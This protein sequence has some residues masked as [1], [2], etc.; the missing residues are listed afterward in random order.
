MTRV[1]RIALTETC[2]VYP[3]MPESLSGVAALE[4]KLEDIRQANI[5]HHLQLA[6]K[7]ADAGVELLVCGE[8]FSAPYFA[9]TA[10]PMWKAMAE[11]ASDGPTVAAMSLAA[12]NHGM[13]IVAPIYEQ[14]ESGARFN[15][16]M[17]IDETG[18]VIG[19]Y[20]KSHIPVGQN[21]QGSFAE[22]FYYGPSD[23][24]NG[25]WEANIS[26]N[27]YFPVFQTSIGK[28]GVAICYDRH[29]DGVMRTLAASGAELVVSPAVTFGEKSERMW[30]MEFEV[31]AA[32][33][34][35][36]IAGSN[37]KGAEKPW[38]QDYFGSSYVTGPNGRRPRIDIGEPA[39]VVAE[40]DLG[41]LHRPDPSGW[42]LARDYRK[43]IYS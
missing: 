29:F 19:K 38:D 9:S 16:A 41:E 5:E 39:L 8:L 2:N 36:F 11:S 37:R 7:A 31:D 13:V 3:H 33:H 23:G 28:L 1:V 14:A 25:S 24:D 40:V 27:P 10:E 22:T 4:G 17:V 34:N 20:R 12:R 18:S 6:Q 26:D 35:L 21:E 30:E 42:D 15:A 32:R 43:D